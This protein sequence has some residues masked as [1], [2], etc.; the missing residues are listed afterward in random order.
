MTETF[1]MSHQVNN[2]FLQT[3]KEERGDVII[4]RLVGAWSYLV[5][6]CDAICLPFD[7]EDLLMGVGTF[8]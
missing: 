8:T 1:A 7:C 3:Y 6:T 2:L 5:K 4:L